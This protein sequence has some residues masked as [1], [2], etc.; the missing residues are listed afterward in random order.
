MRPFK[1]PERNQVNEQN[2]KIFD[3]L[4]NKLGMVPNIYATYAYSDNAL[5]RYM[6]FANGK[7]SLS[8]KEKE[9]V[10]LVVSQINGCSYCLAAHT[11]LAKMNG[12]TDDQILQI[13]NGG[14]D[15][16]KKLDALA[17]LASE[18]TKNRGIIEDEQLANF[19]D[20]GFSRENLVDLVLAVADKTAT[21]LLHNIT[22]IPVDF[23]EAPELEPQTH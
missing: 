5:G 2:Q 23:P 9:V 13:R 20:A 19:F 12:F 1:V 11:Q 17:K 18:I 21:N 4:E 22:D 7:T 16:D 14:A 3:N 15:F 6:S 8:T 10:N